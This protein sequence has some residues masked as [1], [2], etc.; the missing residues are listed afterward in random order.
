MPH[1]GYGSS[2]A[3]DVRVEYNRAMSEKADPFSAPFGTLFGDHMTVATVEAGEY[4]YSGSPEPMESFSLHPATHA[5]HYGSTVFEGL[6]AHR[7]DD[8]SVAIFRLDDHVARMQVSIGKLRMPVPDADLIRQMIVDAATADVSHA[9][10]S[11]GSLYLRPTFIGTAPN[12]G[13]A[14]TPSDTGMLYVIT[15]P[16]GDYFAGG[17]RPLTI[18]IEHETPRTTPQFGIC[19]L[20]TSPSPRDA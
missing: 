20:Y 13:A 15:S 12:I 17:I 5:L 8:G 1:P 11:P 18:Y 19:L 16:V 3:P 4:T 14:A 9:P 7:Q 6:K 10:N 2:S